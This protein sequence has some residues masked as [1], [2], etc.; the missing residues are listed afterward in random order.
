MRCAGADLGG[1]QCAHGLR[2]GYGVAASP[3]AGLASAGSASGAS[4]Q[5]HS[6]LPLTAAPPRRALAK[7]A[8]RGQ[9]AAIR[10]P[11]P[12]RTSAAPCPR[13]TPRPRALAAAEGQLEGA[14]AQLVHADHVSKGH[15]Q[16]LSIHLAWACTARSVHV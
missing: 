3:A 6:R 5:H 15:R 1:C 16:A 7:L 4:M 2:G 11:N 14:R 8:G 12:R 13:Y 9:A 10:P